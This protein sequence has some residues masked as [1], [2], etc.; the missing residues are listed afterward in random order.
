[1][2]PKRDARFPDVLALARAFDVAA[3]GGGTVD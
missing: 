1:M 2:A 3:G